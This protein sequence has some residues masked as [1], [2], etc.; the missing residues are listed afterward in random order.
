MSALPP[1]SDGTIK[2]VLDVDLLPGWKTYWRDPGEA[3]VP[4][5]WVFPAVK[6]LKWLK[7]ISQHQNA[8]QTTIQSGPATKFQ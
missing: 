2:A 7:S 3:G 6:I 8:L 5:R 4:P 1:E